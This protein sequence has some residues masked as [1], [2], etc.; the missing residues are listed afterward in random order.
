M[1]KD[2][3]EPGKPVD[4]ATVQR[5]ESQR[6]KA[7]AEPKQEAKPRGKQTKNTQAD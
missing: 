1:N 2:G 6:M 5:I 4:F 7:K 3:L